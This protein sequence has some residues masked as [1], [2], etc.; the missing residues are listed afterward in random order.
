MRSSLPCI[1]TGV[2]IELTSSF[3]ALSK[4]S[5]IQGLADN[6]HKEYFPLNS[7]FTRRSALM[8]L[9]V[10]GEKAG[11]RGPVEGRHRCLLGP[12]IRAQAQIR[13]ACKVEPTQA[14]P[15]R[16][17]TRISFSKLTSALRMNTTRRTD[18]RCPLGC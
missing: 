14:R 15:L 18:C 6:L 9:P 3:K 11:F 12:A 16:L 7:D 10:E 8:Y 2:R 5:S 17:H 4:F 1:N 13:T